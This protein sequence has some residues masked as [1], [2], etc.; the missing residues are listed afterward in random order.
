MEG[1]RRNEKV[2]VVGNLNAK[3]RHSSG[4]WEGVIGVGY[5]GIPGVNGNGEKLIQMCTE[6]DLIVGRACFENEDVRK[7]MW[8]R[9]DNGKIGPIDNGIITRYSRVNVFLRGAEGGMLGHYL[10][11]A[12]L[13]VKKKRE[14]PGRR[15]R[16]TKTNRSDQGRR[17]TE[18]DASEKVSEQKLRNYG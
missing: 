9:R 6:R 11:E 15:G 7:Q 1:F 10:V 2:I 13:K 4:E 8:V 3:A 16:D 12:N 18:K 5:S 17:T 14:V